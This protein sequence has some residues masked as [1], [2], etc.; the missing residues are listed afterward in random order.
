[1]VTRDLQINVGL[2]AGPPVRQLNTEVVERKGLG[3]PDSICDALAEAF[4]VSLCRFYRERFGIIL[5]HNVDKALLCAGSA[6]PAFGG[7]QVLEPIEVFLAGRATTAFKGIEVPAAELAVETSRAWLRRHFHALDPNRDVR[8]HP[9]VRPGSQD[10]AELY[11]R[12]ERTGAYLANDTS[13]GV[14]FAPLSALEKAVFEVE[15]ELNSPTFRAANP[16]IGQDIKVMGVRH[17]ERLH[18]TIACAAVDRFL[19]NLDEYQQYKTAVADFARTVAARQTGTP[20]QISVNAAD[21]LDSESVYL[22]VTG[23]SGESGDDGEAGRGNRVNGLITPYR[24]MTMESVA[25]KNPVSHVGKLYNLC[26][27]LITQRLVEEIPDIVTAH[28]YMVS[29][30]GRPIDQPQ[31]VDVRIETA[32]GRTLHGLRPMVQNVVRREL[33]AMR[34]LADRLLAGAIAIDRWPLTQR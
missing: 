19:H 12:Q 33:E 22:T 15:R 8:I 25:G 2:L 13:C 28:C 1:M 10:L 24:P 34:D 31:I 6:R 29:E 16:A 17:S 14:G 3:H 27:S 9:L 32:R 23:T 26:A 5:H 4:S 30:I 21:D 11:L 18:L 20:V 7:G